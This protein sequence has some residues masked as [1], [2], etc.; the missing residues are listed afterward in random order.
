MESICR[1]FSR[2]VG[3]L[4]FTPRVLDNRYLKVYSPQSLAGFNS[5]VDKWEVET[6][7]ASLKGSRSALNDSID[8]APSAVVYHAL[9]NHRVTLNTDVQSLFAE[10]TPKE[11]FTDWP[12]RAPPGLLLLLA[13]QNSAVR[14]WAERQVEQ[15]VEEFDILPR[16]GPHHIVLSALARRL[17]SL[18]KTSAASRPS[19]ASPEALDLSTCLSPPQLWRAFPNVIRLTAPKDIAPLKNLLGNLNLCQIVVRHVNDDAER[20]LRLSFTLS[21]I[22]ELRLCRL[23]IRT[24]ML[25]LA[26]N[27]IHRGSLG[28]GIFRVPSSES[29]CHSRQPDA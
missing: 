22:V 1:D 28:R 4:L 3:V 20:E 13:S 16:G 2:F 5:N 17:Q 29:G 12:K 6:I 24:R 7:V 27:E 25:L 9:A 21:F 10:C 15:H 18:D 23:P 14:S 8:Q 11:V 26:H 19:T